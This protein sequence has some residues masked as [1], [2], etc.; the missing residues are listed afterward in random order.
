MPSHYLNQCWD[1]VNW[2]LRNELQWNFNQNS[3]I[4]IQENAFENVVWKTV[5]ILS[6][7]QCVIW[8]NDGLS[9][10]VSFVSSKFHLFWLFWRIL[11]S[12]NGDAL[13]LLLFSLLRSSN[14]IFCLFFRRKVTM[15]C[16]LR[17][18]L[19]LTRHRL[20][21]ITPKWEKNPPM[22]YTVRPKNYRYGSHFLVLF[23]Q[24]LAPCYQLTQVD[25]HHILHYLNSLRLSDAYM[26]Q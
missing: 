3:Y 23:S 16:I 25:I 21:Y 12:Y 4:F 26:H 5:A 20:P 22:F 18:S 11:M 2:T 19:T 6:R 15:F 17:H 24:F 13:Q 7:P 10:G 9:Y 1:I 8:P 14:L